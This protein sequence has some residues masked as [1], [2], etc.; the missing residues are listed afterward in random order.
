MNN[1]EAIL[2]KLES[3]LPDV[4]LDVKALPTNDIRITVSRQS[5]LALVDVLVN[6]G[7]YDHL[8]TITGVDSGEGVELLY[9]FWH[10]NGV[11]VHL[12][13]PYDALHMPTLTKMVPGALFYEREVAEMLGVVFEGLDAAPLVLPDDWDRPP[14]LR[15]GL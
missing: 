4:T 15:K 6:Q 10:K 12:T 11:S 8:S 2:N 7:G 9:H 5:F 3:A 13:L 1:H 14:P